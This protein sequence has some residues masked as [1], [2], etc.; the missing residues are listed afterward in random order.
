MNGWRF[1]ENLR[2]SEKG[3]TEARIYYMKKISI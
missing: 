2:G 3:E 1:G